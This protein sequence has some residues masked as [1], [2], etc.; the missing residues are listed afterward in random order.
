MRN[1]NAKCAAT[2]G[3]KTDELVKRQKWSKANEEDRKEEDSR[4]AKVDK[5]R[6]IP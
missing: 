1:T 4:E 6:S 2:L 5:G 3:E